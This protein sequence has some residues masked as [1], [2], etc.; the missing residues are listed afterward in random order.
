MDQLPDSLIRD[1]ISLV[2]RMIGRL[3]KLLSLPSA[4]LNYKRAY[5]NYF[6]VLKGISSNKYPLTGVLRSGKDVTI[7]NDRE[8]W[9]YLLVE[10]GLVRG[11]DYIVDFNFEKDTATV[12]STIN[13]ERKA[14]FNKILNNGDIWGIFLKEEYRKFNVVDKLVIDIGANVAD[15]SIYFMLQGARHVIAIEP[16]PSNAAIAEG[17]IISNNFSDRITLIQAGCSASNSHV[18]IDD[19]HQTSSISQLQSSE[20]G[21]K[22]PVFTLETIIR[23]YVR[24]PSDIVIKMDCEGCEYDALLSTTDNA[25]EK[26]SDLQ[27]E[28]HYGNHNLVSKLIKSGF[29][30]YADRPTYWIHRETRS[31]MYTGFVRATRGS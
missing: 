10:N 25:L 30:V 21:T 22:I 9:Y 7:H 8:S 23:K 26:V 19:T 15:S 6:T 18:N 16:F 31:P 4:F 13:K 11:N 28:Y 1:N 29:K 2:D 20:R 24:E 27:I 5:R 14:T 12:S 17:N 3:N